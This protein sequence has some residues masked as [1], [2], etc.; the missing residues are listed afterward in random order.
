MYIYITLHGAIWTVTHS[1]LLQEDSLLLSTTCTGYMLMI[2]CLNHHCCNLAWVTWSFA[3]WRY[4]ILVCQHHKESHESAL[5][6]SDTH[7]SH[8]E[9]IYMYIDILYSWYKYIFFEENVKLHSSWH[10][11]IFCSW[12]VTLSFNWYRLH[13]PLSKVGVFFSEWLFF[14]FSIGTS[15]WQDIQCWQ[16][17]SLQHSW[18]LFPFCYSICW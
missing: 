7:H 15:M 2:Y 10:C 1:M 3:Q 13:V 12:D 14:F 5:S 4:G 8:A 16:R 17:L 9:N 6:Q 18:F 11:Q